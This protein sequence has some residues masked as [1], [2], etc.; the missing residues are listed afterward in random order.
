MVA[1][2]DPQHQPADAPVPTPTEGSLTAR[3]VAV[4]TPFFAIA[5]GWL[6]GVISRAIPGVVLNEADVVAFM[7]AAATSASAAAWKWLQGW[8]QHETRVSQ[9]LAA[10]IR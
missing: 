7:I 4:L 2:F 1:R 8:Q 3:F 6:A 5:A 10:P 9:G